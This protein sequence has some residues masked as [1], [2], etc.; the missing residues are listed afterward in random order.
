MC[1]NINPAVAVFCD[2]PEP[3]RN[4]DGDEIPVWSVYVGDDQADPVDTVYSLHD[5]IAA[6]H[7]AARIAEDRRLELVNEAMPD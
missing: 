5:Y 6:V 3:D 4:H 2:G 7:L 1:N